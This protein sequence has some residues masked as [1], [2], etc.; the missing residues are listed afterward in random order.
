MALASSAL[1]VFLLV[2]H[3]YGCNETLFDAKYS[4]MLQHLRYIYKTIEGKLMASIFALHS[5]EYFGW[6]G[7]L[8]MF[9]ASYFMPLLG[10]TGFLLYL[11]KRK[12]K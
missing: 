8:G 1:P 3:S 11:K 6:F 12:K 10:I 9:I 7:Q 5:G 2:A 4:G